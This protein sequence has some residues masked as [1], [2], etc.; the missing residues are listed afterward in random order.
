[1]AD[2]KYLD[3]APG[4]PLR[5]VEQWTCNVRESESGIEFRSSPSEYSRREWDLSWHAAQRTAKV[6]SIRDIINYSLGKGEAFFWKEP[7]VTSR[8]RIKVGMGDGS[9][10]EYLLPTKDWA[11]QTIRVDNVEVYEGIDYGYLF[12][13]GANGMD[14]LSFRT[15][16][17]NGSLVDLDYTDGYYIAL[18]YGEYLDETLLPA[19]YNYYDLD[20]TL[21]ETREEW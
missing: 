4:Y 10:R 3:I 6:E 13:A 5:E 16:P 14:I 9:R 20:L 1:M 2:R 17:A 15:A 19:G 7:N 18:V 8:N 21:R 11:F 12:D